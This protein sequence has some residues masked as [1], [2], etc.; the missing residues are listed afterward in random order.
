M[1]YGI[2]WNRCESTDYQV[3]F[4]GNR[5]SPSRATSRYYDTEGEAAE[6]MRFH[7]AHGRF[8]DTGREHPA[9]IEAAVRAA[10]DDLEHQHRVEWRRETGRRF[11]IEGETVTVRR[12]ADGDRLARALDQ[13]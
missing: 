8:P 7:Q 3:T 2:R 12:V 1:A 6:A 4:P 10:L 13:A 11:V 9:A 5:R